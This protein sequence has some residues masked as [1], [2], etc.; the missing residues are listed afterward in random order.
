M[1]GQ[2]EKEN[3]TEQKLTEK[4]PERLT[5]KQKFADNFTDMCTN[6]RNKPCQVFM[7]LSGWLCSIFGGIIQKT[8]PV[9]RLFVI[10]MG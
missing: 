7:Y 10:V 5:E 8:N 4:K 9:T 2:N 1:N 3:R 6:C